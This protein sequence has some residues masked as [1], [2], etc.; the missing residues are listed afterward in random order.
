MSTK[1]KCARCGKA[2]TGRQ[3]KWCSVKC[4]NEGSK[5]PES[6]EMK[7]LIEVSIL[8]QQTN[9]T[10]I[11]SISELSKRVDSLVDLFEEAAKNVGDVKAVTQ[12]E[13]GDIAKRIQE[14]VLQNRDLAEGLLNL[15]SYVKRKENV[16]PR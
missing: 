13:V 1:L 3:K 15:D 11:K 8:T 10:L 6:S 4:R 12:E 7:K 5:K 9:I 14:V 2:L 16:L